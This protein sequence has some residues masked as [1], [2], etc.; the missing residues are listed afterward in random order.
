MLW[1]LAKWGLALDLK[2]KVKGVSDSG[3]GVLRS[4]LSLGDLGDLLNFHPRLRADCW[5]QYEQA[6][7]TG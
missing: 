3:V 4:L 7:L 1:A 2:A 6:T 5:L